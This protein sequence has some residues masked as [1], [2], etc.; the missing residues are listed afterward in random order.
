MKALSLTFLLQ[1]SLLPVFAQDSLYCVDVQQMDFKQCDAFN[2]DIEGKKMIMIGEE[3]HQVVN[4]I[5]Q[6]ELLIYLNQQFGVR[7]LLIEFGRA[8]AYLYNQYLQ[9][10]EEWY[11]NHT[12]QG[13]NQYKEFF[14]YWKKL[15]DYNMGLDNSK[16]LVVH[17]LDFEREPGLSAS[18]SKLLEAYA[19]HPQVKNLQDTLKMRLDTI[20]VER[21]TKAYI[22]HLRKSI[23]SLALP[24]GENKKVIDYIISN[25]AFLDNLRDENM[26]QTFMALDSTDEVYLGQFGAVHAIMYNNSMLMSKLN[27]HERY[28]DKILAV[29]MYRGDLTRSNI[30]DSVSPCSNYLY[31]INPSNKQLGDFRYRGHW[32]FYS[33]NGAYYTTEQ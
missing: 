11:L 13:F 28:H 26:A 23:P 30:L 2:Q 14:T 5:L 3:H 32:I 25:N 10:G 7:H 22:Y 19:D 18:L 6:T 8:E 27:S 20:G 16:K 4:S 1:L 17:G 33:K 15:Y 21:D 12:F 31:K 29:H 9:T 24:E